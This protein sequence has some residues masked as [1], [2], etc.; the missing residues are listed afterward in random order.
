M[1]T[2]LH[3][4][5]RRRRHACGFTLVELLAVLAIASVLLGAAAPAFTALVRSV[6]LTTATNDLFGGLLLARSEAAKRNSRAV[7][8][9]SADGATCTAAGGWEQGWIVFHDA[10]NNALRDASEPV[11]SRMQA[12]PED[13]RLSGNL[14]V[15]RYVSYS[16]TG[17]SRLVGGGFQAG[18]ITLCHPSLRGG[19]AR[20][21]VISASGRPRVQKTSVA[22]CA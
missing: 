18:T 17:E 8:C 13:L 19:E 9:K 14:N 10:D 22:D 1:N 12:L 21:I 15:A 11:I 3:T 20:S 6:K 7:V 16:P 5:P 4:L 2:Q